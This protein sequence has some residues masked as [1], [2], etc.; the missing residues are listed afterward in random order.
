LVAAGDGTVELRESPTGGVDAV[1]R[2]RT[3]ERASVRA[4]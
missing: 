3:A 1:V 4:T 2:F